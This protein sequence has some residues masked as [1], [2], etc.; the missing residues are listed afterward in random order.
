M[1]AVVARVLLYLTVCGFLSHLQAQSVYVPLNH[2][3][4]DFV[5]RLEAKGVITGVLNGTKPYS[6]EEM[7]EYLFQVETKLKEGLTLGST[8]QQ[9]LE[10]LRFEFKEEFQRLTGKNGHTYIT[11]LQKIK[12]NKIFGKIFPGFIY[13]NHRNIFHIQTDDFKVFFDPVFSH[14]WSY[15]GVDSVKS[16][17]R[18]LERTHGVRFWG[19][20]GT[21]VGFYFDARDTKEWGTRA[22][23][24]R[25]DISMN[26]LGF[27]N[28]YGTHIWHDETVAYMVF[29]LPHIQ[30][31]LGK[32]SNY[33]GSGFNGALSLSDNATSYD[34]IKLQAK[35]WRLKFTYFWGFLRTFPVIL[36][37]SGGTQDKNI[38]AHR[39]EIDV[40]KWLDIGL[41]ET[42]VF[43]NR[44]LELAY[45]NPINFYRSAEH[46]VGDND[47]A[48]LGADV[49]FLLIPNVKLYG[50]L[51][52][53][54]LFTSRLGTGWFGNKTA[55]LAGGLW[56][57]AFKVPNLDMRLEYA[58]TRPYVYTHQKAINTYSH[59]STGLGHWIGPNAEVLN[60]R[61]Q[62]RLSKSLFFAL[63]FE[64]FRHGANE[65]DRNVGGDINRPF[66]TGDEAE[67][68]SLDGILESRSRFGFEI[69]Y[70][71]FRNFYFDLSLNTSTSDNILLPTGVRGPVDRNQ[72]L[73][74]LSLN[75]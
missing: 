65:S 23:P 74:N 53:D 54:D 58:R 62:Y 70:E 67:I 19:Q 20:L 52:I 9:Q 71:L 24:N 21:H 14:K 36:D 46:F 66:E 15:A 11:R 16:T 43:G 63:N 31:T 2:W 60:L 30:V 34:Q 40:T 49:D 22:Y 10:F 56:V 33:W 68:S 61:L 39:L 8:E 64:S 17:E 1:F 73:F 32:D 50:E 47:N 6:R 28:G 48:T 18:V 7:V 26:G 27:V 37:E 45:L 44:R 5:E 75:R 38:V 51:F 72:V 25:F 59:F 55:F 4:Y 12:E 13:K 57:D 69:S 42:V 41:Y 29:K 35:F 3:S